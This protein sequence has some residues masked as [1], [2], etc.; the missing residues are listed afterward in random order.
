[1][2]TEPCFYYGM[3]QPFVNSNMSHCSLYNTQMFLLEEASSALL[4]VHP[5]KGCRGLGFHLTAK[6]SKWWF[7]SAGVV[8]LLWAWPSWSLWMW[9]SCLLHCQTG[10]LVPFPVAA[11]GLRGIMRRGLRVKLLS[12]HLYVLHCLCWMTLHPKKCKDYSCAN[13][14]PGVWDTYKW[15]SEEQ[16]FRRK[17][18]YFA[19]QVTSPFWW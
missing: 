17:N 3:E 2:F 12:V 9:S 7:V 10:A 5:K 1:M 18:R 8:L 13:S 19:D 15:Y 4:P 16:T 14:L 11:S 6:H